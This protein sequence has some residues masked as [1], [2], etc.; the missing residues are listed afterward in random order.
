MLPVVWLPSARDDLP[1]IL[2]YI[3]QEN[4]PAAA[5]QMKKLR[6]LVSYHCPNIRTCI[7]K[8]RGC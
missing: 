2:T 1:Q 4:P 5:R 6:K 8:M 7:A 3:A